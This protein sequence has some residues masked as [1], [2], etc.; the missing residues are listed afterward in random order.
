MEEKLIEQACFVDYEKLVHWVKECC[1]VKSMVQKFSTK[2][3]C[4]TTDKN[5]KFEV[6]IEQLSNCHS[7]RISSRALFS[8]F[9]FPVFVKVEM[10]HILR[11]ILH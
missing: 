3:F 10:L 4:R 8:D 6:Q 11:L 7:S 5:P 2:T 9:H 1:N